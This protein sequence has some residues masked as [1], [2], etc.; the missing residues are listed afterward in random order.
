MPVWIVSAAVRDC[1]TRQQLKGW[2]FRPV[3]EADTELHA[4]YLRT[5]NDLMAQVADSNPRHFF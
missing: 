3:L 4:G 5:W 2:A 1:F